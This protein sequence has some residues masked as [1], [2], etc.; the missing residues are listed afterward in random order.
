ML[1]VDESCIA[2]DSAQL[3]QIKKWLPNL[4]PHG[5]G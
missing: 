2:S 1:N 4:L 5:K 3:C